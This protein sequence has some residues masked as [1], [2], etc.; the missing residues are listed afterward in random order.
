MLSWV[1]FLLSRVDFLWHYFDLLLLLI[2]CF[3]HCHPSLQ[4]LLHRCFVYCHP[5]LQQWF[6]LNHWLLARCEL[7]VFFSKGP[8]LFGWLEFPLLDHGELLQLVQSFQNYIVVQPQLNMSFFVFLNYFF[9]R[10]IE[11]LNHISNARLE[12]KNVVIIYSRRLVII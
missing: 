9:L 4:L 7:I 1:D 2:R 5:S 12:V 8:I 6:S 3:V 11:F 10:S